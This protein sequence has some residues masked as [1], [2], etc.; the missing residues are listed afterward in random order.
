MYLFCLFILLSI[1]QNCLPMEQINN[2]VHMHDLLTLFNKEVQ[3]ENHN[4]DA[5]KGIYGKI[6]A[7]MEVDRDWLTE[8]EYE[9]LSSHISTT[10]KCG[11]NIRR[12]VFDVDKEERINISIKGLLWLQ[13]QVKNETICPDLSWV[14]SIPGIPSEK[15]LGDPEKNSLK[16]IRLETITH[17]LN[18]LGYIPQKEISEDSQEILFNLPTEEKA[19]IVTLWA[20]INNEL[21][22]RQS[23]YKRI[24]S[25]YFALEMLIKADKDILK[26]EQCEEINDLLN[27]F[28]AENMLMG[29]DSFFGNKQKRAFYKAFDLTKSQNIIAQ[30]QALKW[31][32]THIKK[33]TCGDLSWIAV[34]LDNKTMPSV[35]LHDLPN[36]RLSALH[37]YGNQLLDSAIQE[38]ATQMQQVFKHQ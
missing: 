9:K 5:I 6:T 11:E 31:V 34:I 18:N 22:K 14:K 36:K 28:Y 12:K 24:R 21:Y 30:M 2:I 25:Y 8:E 37:I 20:K 23:C 13:E 10:I 17:Q 26:K 15:F 38:Q 16:K 32:K 19:E 7:I 27:S 29:A 3:K 33:N 4:P 35:D 1:F